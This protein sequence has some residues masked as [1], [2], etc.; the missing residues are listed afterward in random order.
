MTRFGVDAN[1]LLRALLN[2]HPQQSGMA[3]HLLAGLGEGR[4][5]H[6]AISAVLEVFWV[7]R[8]R[9][10]VPRQALYEMMRRLLMTRH[11]EVE[12]SEAVV[13]ALAHY[14]EGRADFQDALLVER[15]VEAG[16]DLT[17]TFDRE[18]ARRLPKMELLA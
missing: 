10:R 4:R 15:N 12:S 6:I 7:L 18:A 11:L 16:C 1:I 5:G 13:R 3:R 8:S 2:D 14:R 9:Y 17:C